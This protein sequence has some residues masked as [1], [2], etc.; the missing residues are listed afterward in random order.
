MPRAS[1]GKSPLFFLLGCVGNQRFVCW[2]ESTRGK[3]GEDVRTKG[4]ERAHDELSRPGRQG[5]VQPTQP[6]FGAWQSR[7]MAG[8]GRLGGGTTAG[9]GSMRAVARCPRPGP[10]P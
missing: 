10:G 5:G 9:S 7:R 3:R 6:Q 1:E 4:C 8:K 2:I